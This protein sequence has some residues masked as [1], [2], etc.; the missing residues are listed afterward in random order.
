MFKGLEYLGC[1]L[2]FIIARITGQSDTPV[3]VPVPAIMKHVRFRVDIFI[4]SLVHVFMEF[5]TLGLTPVLIAQVID[6]RAACQIVAEGDMSFSDR[7]IDI[8][9]RHLHGTLAEMSILFY[10]TYQG[11]RHH[12]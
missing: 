10:R 3:L 7:A 11:Y 8:F 1:P 4:N 9:H 2:I 12:F 5:Y 6:N